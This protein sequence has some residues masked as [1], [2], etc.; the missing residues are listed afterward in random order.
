MGR[1][2]KAPNYY[3]HRLNADNAKLLRK[4]AELATLRERVRQLEVVWQ[5]K[6]T[7]RER[8]AISNR[9]QSLHHYRS[10]R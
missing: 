2:I 4:F 9:D 5:A 10:P 7:P 3:L 1:K 6:A 8:V